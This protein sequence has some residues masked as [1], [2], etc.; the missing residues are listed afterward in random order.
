I[1]DDPLYRAGGGGVAAA[2]RVRERGE[3]VAGAGDDTREGICDPVGAGSEPME[4]DPATAGGE[5]DPGDGWCG[6]GDVAGVGRA[7]VAGGAGSGAFVDA[8]GCGGIIDEKFCGAA[9]CE[10]RLATRSYFRGATSV[11]SG[12][13]Q[14]GGPSDGI[15]PAAVAAAE[16]AAGRGGSDRNEYAA[17]VWRD[18]ER[19]RS[20]REDACGK[21]E[22]DVSAGQRGIFS[23][24]QDSIRGW[25]G[26]HGS[27]SEWSAQAGGS[28]PDVCKKIFGK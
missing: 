11:A 8:A 17:A 9:G 22:G 6:G 5:P 14:D 23:S 27:G 26:F 19:H 28:E 21:M 13:V 18:S 20:S 15:L 24:A 16:G 4:A 2:D 25:Q 7:E 1:Q 3:F 12:T 10:A